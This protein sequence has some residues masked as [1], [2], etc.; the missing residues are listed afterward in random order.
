M[1]NAKTNV[2]RLTQLALLTAIELVMRAVG[3]GAVPVGPLNM[4]FLTLP[5]AVGAM[6]VGPIGGI[7]LGGIFG[8]LSLTD[9]ISGRSA[10]TG[11]F[12]G[13]SPLKTI[14]LCVGMRVLMGLCCALVFDALKRL[15]RK[16]TWSYYVGAVSAPVLN[17]LFFMGYIVLAFY[18]TDYVQN[19]AAR[20]GAAN[21]LLFVAALVGVQ[22]IVEAVACGILG[23][24]VARAVAAYVGVLRAK[25]E[26]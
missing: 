15:D 6:L 24:G 17:T 25:A 7:V 12:F 10:M 2:R 8:L 3:L 26:A 19:L 1:N 5:V 9:A 13:I 11:F 23:G 20:L 4:S 18:G 14:V 21:P 22:G 16:G